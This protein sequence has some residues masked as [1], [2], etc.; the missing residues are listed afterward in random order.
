MA[1]TYKIHPAIGLARVGDSPDEFFVG[2]ERPNEHPA[3]A[4]GFK[5]DQCRIKRQA[6]R[7]RVFAHHDDGTTEEIT[8]G[9]S[10]TV[11]LANAKAADPG[12][13]NTEPAA[14]LTIDP[15][16]RTLDGPGQTALFDTGTITFSGQ[17][18]VTVPLGEARTEADGRLLVLGG[19]GTS[20]SPEGNGIQ[21][22]WGNA[23]WYDDVADGPVTATL[24]LPDGSTPP[25]EG[26][27][28]LVGPPKFAPHQDNVITLYDRLFDRMV[29]LGLATAPTTTSYTHDVYPVLRRAADSKWVASVGG[30]HAWPHPVTQQ[31]TI[32]RI[33]KRLRPTGDMPA[34][35][36][37]DA[38]LTATQAA[39]LDRWKA[40]TYTQDW[41]GEPQPDPAITP[42]GLDRAA[43]DGAVGGAFFPGIEAGGLDEGRRPILEA[44]YTAAFRLDHTAVTPG[45]VTSSM[46]LPWQADF[47]ACADTWWPVPRPL[48]VYENAEATEQIRWDRDVTSGEEMVASWNTLGFIVGPGTD[49]HFETEHCTPPA[50]TLLTPVVRF[51]DVA[52]GPLGMV[53]EATASIRFS[54]HTTVTLELDPPV[55]PQ[56]AARTRSVTVDP[57]QDPT[58]TFELAYRTGVAPSAIPT[59]TLTVR[60]P[61]A[62]TTW[63]ISV[64]ANTVPRTG[65]ATVLVVDRSNSM[66]ADGRIDA[67]RRVAPAFAALLP[68]GDGLGVVGFDADAEVLQEVLILS[69]DDANRVATVGVLNGH[70]L[71]PRGTTSIG[72]GVAAGRTAVNAG[73]F[74]SRSL[75]VLTDGIEN[76]PRTLTEVIGEATTETV[77]SVQLGRPNSIGVPPLSDLSGLTGGT[78]LSSGEANLDE[79]LLQILADVSG[80]DV[81]FTGGG[82]LTDV[83]RIPF[84]VTDADGGFDVLLSTATPEAVDFRL[85]TPG[86]LL[87]EPWLA[88]GE[89]A[90]RY[91]TSSGLAWYRI[92]L[93]VALKPRRFEQGG[94]WN[95]VVAPGQPRRTPSEQGADTSIL[96]GVRGRVPAGRGFA[97]AAAAPPLGVTSERE[98]A[99]AVINAPTTIH[100]FAAAT[101]VATFGVRVHAWS[102][103][104][105]Q[106]FSTQDSFE[107]GTSVT[108]GAAVTQ[109][110]EAASEVTVT[111]EI[112]DPAGRV[113]TQPLPPSDDGNFVTTFRAAAA[114][115]YRARLLAT[116]RT[117]AGQHF[118]RERLLTPTTW[119]TP[120]PAP[121]DG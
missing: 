62:G 103:I 89:P 56:L 111:A 71:D 49:K 74:G 28:V 65:N 2:P 88:E 19:H 69:D 95:V 33:V 14:E 79:A 10:W 54:V 113:T 15:G 81:V 39:H 9:V 4:D 58:A 105:L 85:Q 59:Q 78:A 61:A 11:H 7:F 114:G 99:Y 100:G 106:A 18:P 40:G 12:R 36:G 23:G 80:A 25:V 8:T 63:Q 44:P 53:A 70:G 116:G 57:A 82:Q 51:A 115:L 73:S 104:S 76:Q 96:R 72:D 77:H 67:V 120:L 43:L 112:T 35:S 91:G 64:D 29:T 92:A 27:W 119:S 101:P 47:Q 32:D 24:T 41:A 83:T 52:Q 50:I 55:H 118:T 3:P 5:D 66:A 1:T 30:A 94:T 38:V 45:A 26:A 16:P 48:D 107:P 13:G 90:M 117:R 110:G 86:G 93:P 109:A 17:Q 46:A 102:G 42:A 60:D 84:T 98:R 22:F 31:R 87:I 34:L 6:A 108:L 37:E 68:S 75:V 20:A 21:D 121:T 97:A